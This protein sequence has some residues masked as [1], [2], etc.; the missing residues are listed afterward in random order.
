MSAVS[1]PLTSSGG[2]TP[3]IG[4]SDMKHLDA[5]RQI[6]ENARSHLLEQ[7]AVVEKFKRMRKKEKGNTKESRE[8]AAQNVEEAQMSYSQALDIFNT[9]Q[10]EE[11]ESLEKESLSSTDLAER[12]NQIE[13]NAADDFLDH[14][15]LRREEDILDE[16]LEAPIVPISSI[17]SAA[18]DRMLVDDI[19]LNADATKVK[20]EEIT[21]LLII[22]ARTKERGGVIEILDSDDEMDVDEKEGNKGEVNHVVIKTGPMKD[23]DEPGAMNLDDGFLASKLETEKPEQPKNEKPVKPKKATI[24]SLQAEYTTLAS[25]IEQMSACLEDSSLQEFVKDGVKQALLIASREREEINKR[26]E[27]LRAKNLK[28]KKGK[29]K[30]KDEG[31]ESGGDSD[32]SDTGPKRSPPVENRWF[33]GSMDDEEKRRLTDDALQ[34]LKAYL[35]AGTPIPFPI[36]RLLKL[37]PGVL[38]QCSYISRALALHILT[39]RNKK[40]ACIFHSFKSSGR[41]L[42]QDNAGK[43]VVYGVPFKAGTLEENT[44]KGALTCGCNIEE[45][46]MDFIFFKI[47]TATSFHPKV[48]AVDDLKW[49]AIHS[50]YRTFITQAFVKATGIRVDHLYVGGEGEQ[51][52]SPEHMLGLVGR[53][54]GKINASLPQELQVTLAAA[55]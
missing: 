45:G 47:A 54:V 49:D 38:P 8:L 15:L 7:E 52:G 2:A 4:H 40:N 1:S 42:I 48:I 16:V 23:E 35:E 51:F 43:F 31:D 55:Q 29:E 19:E 32:D 46:L 17:L 28:S 14:E 41:K 53:V 12:L 11:K 39:T 37:V 6:L 18:V 10:A 21:H 33:D 9:L 36:R 5:A 26:I 20:E 3:P 30:N 44:P 22:P 25:H 34:A 27:E 13:E 24:T 50:R